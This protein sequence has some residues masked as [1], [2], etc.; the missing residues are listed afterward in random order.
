MDLLLKSL[1]LEKQILQEAYSKQFTAI[2]AV[3][4]NLET[5][6]EVSRLLKTKMRC[7]LQELKKASAKGESSVEV[8]LLEQ[9]WVELRS[10]MHA[11]SD[12]IS[13]VNERMSQILSQPEMAHS[14]SPQSYRNQ[15]FL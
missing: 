1:S 2:S 3:V 10:L 7:S 5:A 8:S 6:I 15:T 14:L 4:Q 13:G 9:K 12:Q 11:L